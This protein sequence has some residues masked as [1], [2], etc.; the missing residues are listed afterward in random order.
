MQILHEDIADSALAN[1]MALRLCVRLT[2]FQR[3]GLRFDGD[4]DGIGR[5]RGSHRKVIN[6]LSEEERQ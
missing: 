2:T 3:C 6:R 4:A 5:H 1:V